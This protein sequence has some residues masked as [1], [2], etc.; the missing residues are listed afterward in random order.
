MVTARPADGGAVKSGRLPPAA[1]RMLEV[2]D[3]ADLF[4]IA[5]KDS[6]PTATAA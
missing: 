2:T 4:R 5:M 6:I 1:Q 3:L